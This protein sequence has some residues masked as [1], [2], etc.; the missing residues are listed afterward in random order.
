MKFP[1]A[2]L[3]LIFA[4]IFSLCLSA[5]TLPD[6][7][8]FDN[9]NPLVY[10]IE[11]DHELIPKQV[12]KEGSYQAVGL[13]TNVLENLF[14]FVIVNAQPEKGDLIFKKQK[15]GPITITA[16]GE[17]IMG[18]SIREVSSKKVGKAKY[19]AIMVQIDREGFEKILA[20]NKLYVEFGKFT[21]LASAEN[22]Q[23]FHYL[24]DRLEKDELPENGSAGYNSPVIH[25]KSYYRKDGTYVKAHTRRRPKN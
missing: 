2:I 11:P 12:E 17:K 24:S 19:E 4:G 15:N 14:V 20:A 9:A 8:V 7:F 1:K 13:A 22:L 5:Q 16:D 18:G 10:H 21:H 25:V 23:A 3:A 6:G